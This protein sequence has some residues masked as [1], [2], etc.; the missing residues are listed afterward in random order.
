MSQ[1]SPP[2][3]STFPAQQS[4]WM[5]LGGSAGPASE[6]IRS[7]TASTSRASSGPSAPAST[8]IRRYGSSRR[9]AYH[10]GQSGGPS[11]GVL[12]RGVLSSGR[13]AITP[14]QGAPKPAAP[15]ACNRASPAPNP[16]AADGV[17]RPGGIIEMTRAVP[18]TASTSGTGTASASASQRR[19]F[20]SAWNA[21]SAPAG[22]APPAP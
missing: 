3:Q 15:A 16:N 2:D 13:L 19:P 11:A 8:A 12:S 1:P 22:P 18:V 17:A 10:G 4:P 6:P 5:R 20:A 14:G 7:V 9:L 21:P